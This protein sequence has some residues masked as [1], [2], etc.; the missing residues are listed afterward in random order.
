MTGIG[1]LLRGC[2]SGKGQMT[3]I[4][5][6]IENHAH[7]VSIHCQIHGNHGIQQLRRGIGTEIPFRQGSIAQRI[8]TQKTQIA[9]PEFLF[10]GNVDI[11]G[12]QIHIE[13]TRLAANRQRGT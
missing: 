5:E 10:L 12:L 3:V 4:V 7:C 6:L 8:Q 13:K 11:A 2:Q 1:K 9:D